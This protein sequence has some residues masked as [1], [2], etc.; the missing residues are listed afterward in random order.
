MYHAE[1]TAGTKKVVSLYL[2]VCHGG[3]GA[4]IVQLLDEIAK[5]FQ[6]LVSW[7]AS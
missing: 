7:R 3:V 4:G 6:I 2:W 5:C 1:H